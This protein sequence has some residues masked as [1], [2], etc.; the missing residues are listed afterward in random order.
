MPTQ[1]SAE[2]SDSTRELLENYVRNHGIKKGFL[3]EQ[4]VLDYIR[5][6]EQLPSDILVPA[7]IV[8]SKESAKK[9][10][11][12]ISRPPKPTSRLRKLMTNDD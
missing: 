11:A 2:I 6:L 10:V 3:I 7:K 9:I 12:H 4:A 1:I 8:L 5:A